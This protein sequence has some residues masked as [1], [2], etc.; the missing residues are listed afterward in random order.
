[1]ELGIE[2]KVA[3]VTGASA[4]I[5]RAV[6]ESLSREGCRVA[7][8][9]RDENRL[10]A[11]ASEIAGRTGGTVHGVAGDVS[12]TEDIA[13]IVEAVG[14]ELGGVEI[15]VVNAG[16]PLPGSF[17][18]LRPEDW[19]AAF[20]L[21]LRSSVELCRQAVA[22]MKEAGW[23]RIV[24]LTSVS[25]KQPIDGLMLSNSLRAGVAGFAK[26]LS[27]EYGRHG[28]L[29]NTVCPGYTLTDRLVELADIRAREAGLTSQEALDS[30][31]SSTPVARI[32][33][34][35]EIADMVC[36]LCSER[37]SYVTGT[38]VPVDGGLHKG[39]L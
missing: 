20:R 28:I 30:M 12:R 38:V 15:L 21:T 11:A 4:G 14:R 6:A 13:K 18:R 39:L 29:V 17:E 36:F 7:I 22:G 33:R 5:G 2:G 35:E 34:P 9:A 8:N 31:A 37:S 16:G 24:L 26:T 27:N 3:L 25:V 19:E 10:Q 1:M 23:G 32:A